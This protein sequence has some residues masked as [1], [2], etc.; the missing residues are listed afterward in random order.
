MST[1]VEE[2]KTEIKNREKQMKKIEKTEY[3]KIRDL[4]V[5]DINRSDDDGIDR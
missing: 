1:L 3:N 2:I 5:E 4:K